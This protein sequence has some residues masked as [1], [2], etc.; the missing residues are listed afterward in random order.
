MTTTS[1]FLGRF[2]YTLQQNAQLI[3]FSILFYSILIYNDPHTCKKQIFFTKIN[4]NK[5]NHF[6]IKCLRET[7]ENNSVMNICCCSEKAIE[8]STRREKALSIVYKYIWQAKLLPRLSPCKSVPSIPCTAYINHL[9]VIFCHQI[10]PHKK[11]NCNSLVVNTCTRKRT[12]AYYN[13]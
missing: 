3:K 13:I 10:V 11:N 6:V 8:A 7:L 12:S 9:Q 2:R 4:T 1:L 5:I